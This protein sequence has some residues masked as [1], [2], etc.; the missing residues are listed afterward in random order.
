M[1]FIGRRGRSESFRPAGT[2]GGLQSD[3]PPRRGSAMWSDQVTQDFILC[4]LE[5]LQGRRQ[6]CLPGAE[7]HCPAVHVGGKS[8]P[9]SPA[10][11]ALLSSLPARAQD[12]LTLVLLSLLL[13]L[14]PPRTDAHCSCLNYTGSLAAP[15]S[16]C[17]CSL[18]S[19]VLSL[20]TSAT[21]LSCCLQ[22]WW[23]STFSLSPGHL[24][25]Q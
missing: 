5:A 12:L 14:C 13:G 22:T 21:P 23:G 18:W 8:F 24:R 25:T 16:H 6:H 15:S 7:A 1:H 4:G 20:R 11:H 3:L 9:L 2:S 19:A 17:S 10:P